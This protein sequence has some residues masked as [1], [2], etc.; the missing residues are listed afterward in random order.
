MR[1]IRLRT[2]RRLVILTVMRVSA[3]VEADTGAIALLC[4]KR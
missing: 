2:G 4:D 1:A 3:D